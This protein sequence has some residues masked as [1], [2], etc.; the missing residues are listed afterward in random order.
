MA[1]PDPGSLPNGEPFD[2]HAIADHPFGSSFRGYDQDEVRAYLHQLAEQ[3]RQLVAQ[4][5]DLQ[6]RVDAAEAA[7]RRAQPHELD[8]HEVATL[9]G[10]EAA[11]VLETA[12]NAASEIRAKAD[13]NAATIVNEGSQQAA[14]IRAEAEDDAV[15]SRR[16]GEED[17][18]ATRAQAESDADEIRRVAE[19][20]A[21]EFRAQVEAE[22]A[23]RKATVDQELASVRAPAEEYAARVRA[24]ADEARAAAE[25]EVEDRRVAFEEEITALRADADEYATTERADA[26]HYSAATRSSADEYAMQI[27]G[28]ADDHAATTIAEADDYAARARQSADEEAER[29]RFEAEEAANAMRVEAEEAAARL[30]IDAEE[31]AATLQTETEEATTAMRAQAE[32]VLASRTAEAQATAARLRREADEEIEQMRAT[33]TSAAEADRERA[34]R[35]V[36]EAQNVRERVL[37]D[38]GR[39]RK[40]ARAHLEQLLA[41]REH[42][43]A[44]YETIRATIDQATRELDLMLPQAKAGADDARNRALT[45]P[46]LTAEQLEAEL[47]A[48]RDIDLPL[49]ATPGPPRTGGESPGPSRAGDD[50]AD[51]GGSGVSDNPTAGTTSEADESDE[52]REGGRRRR[53]AR[54]RRKRDKGADDV[55]GA[56]LTAVEPEADFEEVRL[57]ASESGTAD[58]G[59]PETTAS[60]DADDEIATT[61][62]D[63]TATA[64]ADDEADGDED[65]TPTAETPIV[66]PPHDG[67]TGSDKG[68]GNARPRSSPARPADAGTTSDDTGGAP[69]GRADVS[70]PPKSQPPKPRGKR[71]GTDALFERIRTENDPPASQAG[72]SAAAMA[73]HATTAIATATAEA[74]AVSDAGS[75][76]D[77]PIDAIFVRRNDALGDVERRLSRK[78]KRALSDEQ[79]EVLDRLRTVKRRPTARTVL[80]DI[81]EREQVYAGVAL[82]YLREAAGVGMGFVSAIGAADTRK[83]GTAGDV[84]NGTH[85]GANADV[86][87]FAD[88]L[89]RDLV[90]HLRPRL[91]RAV[92]DAGE[93]ADDLELANRVRACYR[94][95]RG[96]WLGDQ[97]RHALITA[98]NKGLF[99]AVGDDEELRWVVDPSTPPCPDCDDNVLAGSQ[100]K[101]EQFPTGQLHPPAHPGCRCLLMGHR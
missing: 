69:A 15:Q 25:I 47:A 39:R 1:Y 88:E 36:D 31:T 33:A 22:L 98:F 19:R 3:L 94:N 52:D 43:L 60:T 34:R 28:E 81:G 62:D 13:E 58:E 27:R 92:D 85:A 84:G 66:P 48:A 41:A 61:A 67:G 70:R 86:Q 96:Q 54:W 100:P 24:E 20:E 37:R 56:N 26:D 83:P 2:P 71:S 32:E 40:Q 8:V 68:S 4:N 30:R 23:H 97:A 74:A 46:E 93:D 17:A 79:S 10:E 65:R 14:A 78:L 21:D 50:D 57:V 42:L 99:D 35:L 75:E 63:A 53:N 55:P 44:S 64:A 38:L 16:Q 72:G 6:R 18:A 87:Q 12:R 11:R 80:G 45:E 51:A 95:L 73:A 49:V 90:A 101:G 7:V 89:A 91:E 29:V 77:D 76:P 82:S 5:T 9:L 59:S